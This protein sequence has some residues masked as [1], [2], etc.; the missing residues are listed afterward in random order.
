[1]DN[2]TEPEHS[3]APATVMTDRAAGVLVGAA[4]GDALGVPWEFKTPR[5]AGTPEMSGGGMGGYSPGEWSDDTQLAICIAEVSATG[6]DL[7]DEAALDAITQRFL[8]WMEAEPREMDSQTRVVF[9]E[10]IADPKIPRT[11][12]RLRNS[13]IFFHRRTRRSNGNGMLSRIPI[14]ALTRLNDAEW[15]S[16]A[17]T[18]VTQLTHIDNQA[19]EAATI[20]CELIRS[21]VIDPR[22]PGPEW[23]RTLNLD[24]AVKLLPWDRQP[25]WNDLLKTAITSWYSPPLD[26]T[27]AGSALQGALAALAAAGA[28]FRTRAFD[29]TE[30]IRFALTQAIHAGGDTDTVAAVCGALLGAVFGAEMLP[31]QWRDEIHGWPGA[32]ADLLSDLAI[33]TATAGIIGQQGMA[34]MVESGGDMRALLEGNPTSR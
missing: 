22:K 31:A 32:R 1:M 10:L 9:G 29:A 28:E 26:N 4:I 11:A 12:R 15:T 30:V 19:I 34:Q 25:L 17:A 5:L 20:L 33:A 13:A 8:A 18:A 14:V 21:A 16:A 27:S 2:T 3:L 7:T 6:A 23:L 24:G